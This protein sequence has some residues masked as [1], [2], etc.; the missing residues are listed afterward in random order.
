MYEDTNLNNIIA[1]VLEE[2]GIELVELKLL[3][4]GPRRIL[5]IYVDQAGGISLERCAE[6]SRQISDILDRKDPIP[7]RFVLEVSSPG[8]DRPLVSEKDFSKN[9][10]R[11]V[12]IRYKAEDEKTDKI[13]GKILSVDQEAVIVAVENT[14]HSIKFNDILKAKIVFEI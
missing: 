14:E 6:A 10:G 9:I 7:S 3:G 1:P 11:K 13:I 12:K 4:S 2:M 5:R 8:A